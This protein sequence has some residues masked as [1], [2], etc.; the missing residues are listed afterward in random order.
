AQRERRGDR[1]RA[2]DRMQRHA[3]RGHAPRRGG[4]AARTSRPGHPLR[5]RRAGH[6]GAV[7]TDP[8]REDWMEATTAKQ[9][10]KGA[11]VSYRKEGG[12]AVFELND[13]PANTYT[14]EMMRDL[15]DAILKARFDAE[16]FVIVIRGAG[17]KFFCAGANINMLQ[18]VDPYFKY[19]FC[20]HANETLT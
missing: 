9:A 11:L 7:R 10:A 17:D 12:I 14:H 3:D 16:V 13:P 5:Q 15:D 20:L 18:T 2:S 8:V 4:A 19:F 6:G 1:A